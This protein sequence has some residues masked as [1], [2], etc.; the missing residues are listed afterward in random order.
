MSPKNAAVIIEKNLPLTR[1]KNKDYIYT[2]QYRIPWEPKGGKKKKSLSW[3][4][5]GKYASK[6]LIFYYETIKYDI[7]TF[8][9]RRY[10]SW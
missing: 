2:K 3:V 8:T 4:P 7:K 5:C 6:T 9:M 1:I 10:G